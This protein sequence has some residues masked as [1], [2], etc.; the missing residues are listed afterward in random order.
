MCGA[1]QHEPHAAH[2]HIGQRLCRDGGEPSAIVQEAILQYCRYLTDQLQEPG[3]LELL[4]RSGSVVEDVFLKAAI[5]QEGSIDAPGPND[6]LQGIR[7]RRRGGGWIGTR[8]LG[9][10]H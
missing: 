2:Q 6:Q 3:I 1:G 7:N 8:D 5:V 10:T 4:A 9:A